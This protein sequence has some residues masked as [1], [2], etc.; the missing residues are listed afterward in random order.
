MG[1]STFLNTLF[2]AELHDLKSDKPVEISSTVKIDSKTFRL[3]EN[4]VRLKLTVVD[5]PGFGDFVDNSNWFVYILVFFKNEIA[6]IF[7]KFL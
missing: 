3:V 7:L 5:T 1:K 6:Y 2:M 4:D